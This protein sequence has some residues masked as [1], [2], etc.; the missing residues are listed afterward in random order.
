MRWGVIVPLF[1]LKCA[2]IGGFLLCAGEG[3]GG[4]VCVCSSGV[5]VLVLYMCVR[6]CGEILYAFG[7]LGRV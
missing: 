4:L 6:F 3:G 5:W 2:W 1:L 7:R